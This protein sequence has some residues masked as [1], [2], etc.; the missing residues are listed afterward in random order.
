MSTNR[1][2]SQEEL[3]S[4]RLKI[5]RKLEDLRADPAK[6]A[7]SKADLIAEMST[8]PEGVRHLTWLH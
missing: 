6:A 2:P 8:A 7:A 3:N 1:S 4:L 5:D